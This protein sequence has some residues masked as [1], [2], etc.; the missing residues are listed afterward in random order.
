MYPQRSRRDSNE[1][2]LLEAWEKLGGWWIPFGPMDGWAFHAQTGFI[3]IEIK[4][5]RKRGHADEF[6]PAEKQHIAYSKA[7]KAPY[8][9]WYTIDDVI[10]T[11]NGSHG[12]VK[13]S[14]AAS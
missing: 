1:P 9:I 7:H 5:P 11:V 14:D 10:E 4:N 12:M 3:C 8:A 6:T 2:E 13:A